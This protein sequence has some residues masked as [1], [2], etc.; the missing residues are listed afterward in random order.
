MESIYYHRETQVF[1]LRTKHT[2]Y[3]MQV[4]Q[5]GILVHLYY[6]PDLGHTELDYRIVEQDHGFSPNPY[7]ADTDRTITL[8]ILP[9][10]YSSY[11]IG[12]YRIC[13]SEIL[14][15]DG[16]DVADF[17]YKSYEIW[18]GKYSLKGLPSM[19]GTPSEAQT[20]SIRLEDSVTGVTAVLLYS[21]FPEL[22]V[23]TRA[24]RF[25]NDGDR[26]YRLRKGMSA[27]LDFLDGPL[28]M[29]HF[30]G[31]H[32][33]E[34][35]PE[36]ERLSHG[37]TQVG[38]R[39]GASS[40][41]QNPFVILCR[42]E[43][44]ED[45]GL[46]YGLS[47]V[48]SGNFLLEAEVDQM[49]QTRVLMGI[50]PAQFWHEIQCGDFFET[51]EVIMTCTTEG[52]SRLSIQLHDALRSNLMRSPFVSKQRPILLNNWEATYFDFDE[53]KLFRIAEQA[54]KLGVDLFVLDDG[55]FGR[56]N[57]DFSGL[58]D[59]WVN[60]EKIKGGLPLL[61]K[62]IQDLGMKL[63]LWIEPEMISEDSALYREHPD[64]C[65]HFP[66]RNPVRGRYQ[67]N[68]DITRK[69]VRDHVMKEIFQVIE[70]CRI[71]YIKWDM[72]RSLGNVYST[73]LAPEK[74]GD[75]YHQYVLALYEMQE[76]LISRFPE[77]LFENCAGGGGRFDA[78]MLYY[79]PQIWCSDNTDAIDRLKIQYGTS[80]GYPVSAMGAHISVCP[81]HQTGRSVP[82]E[83][84]A[85]VASAGTFGFELD[86]VNLSEEEAA[87]AREAMSFYRQTWKLRQL[88]DYYRLSDPFSNQDYVIWEF[89]SKSKDEALTE[90]VILRHQPNS[91]VFF[92]HLRGLD[93]GREYREIESGKVYTGA[94]LMTAGLPLPLNYGDFCAFR[95]HFIVA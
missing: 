2:M 68:L 71:S 28:D 31:R 70:S 76:S 90:G 89:V 27:Q 80:F 53:E 78:G 19:F 72:N 37:V 86:P 92:L 55:W 4:R 14:S 43:T 39:R 73:A 20:L 91:P 67:L 26:S 94:A 57:S 23:I 50:H 40:H 69:E 63:G 34:R 56:R 10:E 11:G 5:F 41:Q 88:G 87:K 58:G 61:A 17:R 52:F 9:Q 44:Q 65:L 12:D 75:V 7:E 21:V 18:E 49:N 6:G 30:H 47:L 62:R 60:E 33:M 95:L 24:V 83:A 66:H 84:R 15:Q 36:R 38:S 22:D 64:W 3:Q 35:M 45:Y 54:K 79:S 81:N 42:P 74:Q 13:A 8:D 93:A 25:E 29:I 16:S 85:V 51:P 77:L 48:Y 32:M 46:C 82:F 1:T 59:W